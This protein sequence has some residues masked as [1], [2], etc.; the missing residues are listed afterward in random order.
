MKKLIL[1]IALALVSAGAYGAN[2]YGIDDGSSIGCDSVNSS[3]GSEE[4]QRYLSWFT[5]YI[6]A[7]N[8]YRAASSN[9]GSVF[10]NNEQKRYDFILVQL[11]AYCWKYP[12]DSLA[13]A[14]EA[15]VER[16]FKK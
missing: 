4:F 7:A 11:S 16:L 2:S 12:E 8:H 14:A 3:S 9:R 1:I 6:S 10:G 13:D 5:G 15:L